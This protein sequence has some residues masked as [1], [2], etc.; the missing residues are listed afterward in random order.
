MTTITQTSHPRIYQ[1]FR[2]IDED[3][4]AET[5]PQI[6]IPKRWGPRHLEEIEAGLKMVSDIQ[7]SLLAIEGPPEM[8]K[9]LSTQSYSI[10]RAHALFEDYFQEAW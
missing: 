6:S 2:L 1:G 5:K 3:S 10:E 8:I 7:L 9:L 4:Q